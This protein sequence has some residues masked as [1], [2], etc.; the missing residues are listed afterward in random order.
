M[1][2]GDDAAS[3]A[4]FRAAVEEDGVGGQALRDRHHAVPHGGVDHGVHLL[5][6]ERANGRVLDDAVAGRVDE[7]TSLPFSRAT[8]CAPASMRPANGVVAIWSEMSPTV[9]VRCW[10]S[11][12]D[13]AGRVADGSGGGADP[14]AGLGGDA[15]LDIVEHERHGGHRNPRGGSHIRDADSCHVD[16]F[17]VINRFILRRL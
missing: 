12:G 14:L 8:S 4:A 15:R 3:S 5:G 10:R 9:L 1:V 6:G 17:L 7:K 16:H 2:V 11:P 13:R